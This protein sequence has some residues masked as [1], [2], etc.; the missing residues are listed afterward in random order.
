MSIRTSLVVECEYE[1]T[2]VA[3]E[4]EYEDT[5]TVVEGGLSTF[6]FA[7]TDRGCICKDGQR[8]YLQRQT[9]DVR[10]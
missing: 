5:Y 1:D 6:V 2:S 8:M 9:E 3:V 4:Y 10:I 7:K